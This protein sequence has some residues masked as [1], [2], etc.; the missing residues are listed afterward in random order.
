[1]NITKI[2]HS[3]QAVKTKEQSNAM[4]DLRDLAMDSYLHSLRNFL[5]TT[6]LLESISS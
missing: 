2:G 1:M 4:L 5:D 3:N 6:L